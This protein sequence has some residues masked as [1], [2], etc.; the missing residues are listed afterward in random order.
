[1]IILHKFKLS[2]KHLD[3]SNS[4]YHKLLRIKEKNIWVIG[5]K[6]ICKIWSANWY[7]NHLFDLQTLAKPS[8]MLGHEYVPFIKR[9]DEIIHP[10]LKANGGL[11]KTCDTSFQI[12]GVI[13]M[14]SYLEPWESK[15]DSLFFSDMIN[16]LSRGV[17]PV[18]IVYDIFS[19]I[20]MRV[21]GVLFYCRRT[22]S[23]FVMIRCHYAYSTG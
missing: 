9:G 7:V 14:P 22:A 1:M 18:I 15:S 21:H 10:C 2:V 20:C 12:D 8:L 6:W 16:W 19:Y 11:V 23:F 13:H 17:V 5:S 3:V 4:I